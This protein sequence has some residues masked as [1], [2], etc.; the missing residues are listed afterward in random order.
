[1]PLFVEPLLTAIGQRYRSRVGLGAASLLP[2]ARRRAPTKI[3][4]ALD[5]GRAN[6]FVAHL[7]DAVLL[8]LSTGAVF[9]HI[10]PAESDQFARVIE[11]TNVEDLG[12]EGHSGDRADPFK[13]SQILTCLTIRRSL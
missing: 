6:P 11:A 1:M 3:L 8:L 5:K 2:L 12:D 13:T 10:E 7:T 9:P 4:T